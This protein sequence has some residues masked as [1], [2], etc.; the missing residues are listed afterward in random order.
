MRRT[1]KP[2]RAHKYQGHVDRQNATYAK[3][4]FYTKIIKSPK[5]QAHSVDRGRS[6]T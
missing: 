1:Q 6:V 4:Q 3:Q 2:R 5:T